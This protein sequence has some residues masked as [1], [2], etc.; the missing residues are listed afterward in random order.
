[1]FTTH[2]T[3][4]QI[5]FQFL[6]PL[7]HL[8]LLLNYVILNLL[9][10]VTIALL[11]PLLKLFL[12]LTV[13]QTFVSHT[14][15]IPHGFLITGDFNLHVDDSE[16]SNAKQFLTLLDSCNLIQLVNFPTHRCDHILDLIV[17]A[18]NS[19]LSPVISHSPISPSDHFPIFCEL[20]IQ[21]PCLPHL[22]HISFRH[23]DAI[24]IPH[25]VRNIF[26]SSLIHN[27]HSSLSELVDCYNF[28]LRV[29]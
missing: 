22:K 16:N 27:P 18:T 15:T 11:P 28:T 9:S 23:I 3:F 7:K 12:S 17:T 24:H 1:L 26:S 5:L 10:S 2:S 8:L 21:P 25:F 20:N 6:N 13:F 19:A 4:S 14:A 29:S